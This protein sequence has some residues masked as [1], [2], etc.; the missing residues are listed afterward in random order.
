MHLKFVK[1]KYF[2]QL[3]T[4]TYIYIYIYISWLTVVEGDLKAPFSVATTLKCRGG[5]YFFLLIAPL[6]CDPFLI[7]LVVKQRGTKYYFL[8]LWY[9]STWDWTLVSWASGEHC[10]HY[11]NIFINKECSILVIWYMLR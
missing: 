8:S 10:N 9:D 11:V 1:K 4:H 7:M 3:N 5:S 2:H 6:N